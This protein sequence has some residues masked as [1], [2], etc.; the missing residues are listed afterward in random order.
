[1]IHRTMETILKERASE[2]PVISV[3]GPRQS[4][5]TTLVKH[6][7]P[8]KAYVSLEDPDTREFAQI[9]PRGFLAHYQDGAILDEIQRTPDLFSYI[10]TTVDDTQKPNHFILTGSNNYLLQERLSQTLAG[11]VAMLKLLPLS[12]EELKATGYPLKNYEDILFQGLYPRIYHQHI[13]PASWYPNYIQTYVERD[14]R[15][16]KNIS[17]LS[18]FQRFLKL[19]AGRIGQILNLSSLGNDCGITH[20]TAKSWLSI[21]ESSF[22]VF[23]LQPHFENF[24]KRLVKQP[25]LYFYDAGLAASLL[26]IESEA[27]LT[28]HYLKGGLFEALIVSE[29]IKFRVHRGFVPQLYYW[30]DHRGNEIDCILESGGMLTPIECKAGK[31]INAD[32]FKGLSFWKSI[33]A[34]QTKKGYVIYGGDSHQIREPGDVISWQESTKVYESDRNL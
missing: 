27:Q 2:Y 6:A 33:A 18:A 25:K 31:T 29:L 28:T 21:L 22:V 4:G 11:R 30:R 13:D 10:Q 17:D 15:L 32:Y 8:E 1:M 16:I 9:D 7:F 26:G 20:N 24:H 34:H 14:V 5:K 19:C 23:L 3:I 12:L